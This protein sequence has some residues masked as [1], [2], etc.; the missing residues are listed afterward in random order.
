MERIKTKC[1]QC[2]EDIPGK[3][4]LKPRLG[5]AVKCPSCDN[6]FRNEWK[7]EL[8]GGLFT[9]IAIAILIVLAI[10][11]IIPLM[12]SFL[13]GALIVIVYMAVIYP[14][15]FRA[16]KYEAKA[17][18]KQTILFFLVSTGLFVSLILYSIFGALPLIIAA[19]MGNVQIVKFLLSIGA[20]PDVRN[21]GIT[22]WIKVE[23]ALEMA[24]VSGKKDVVVILIDRGAD[25]HVKD[26]MGGKP[27]HR[28]VMEENKEIVSLL[29]SNGADVNAKYGNL[30]V[31][32]LMIAADNG[33]EDV[34][35]ILIEN[36][37][38]INIRGK[39][40]WA[41]SPLMLA[42]QNCHEGLVRILIESGAKV[43]LRTDM[44][45]T[46]STLAK[47]CENKEIIQILSGKIK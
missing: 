47:D 14:L 26:R 11:D 25:I 9:G 24:I 36:G 35:K 40:I 30:D 34:A 27:I 28:A 46:A 42:A 45:Q 4:L 44:G 5:Q 8:L 39:F 15:V 21:N 18:S 29:L 43:H 31:T 10:R 13:A 20:D 22:S 7:T 19:R 6:L 3:L 38:E 33:F 16:R 23:Y 12:M 41:M 17:G 37:A 1:P 32:P 2:N